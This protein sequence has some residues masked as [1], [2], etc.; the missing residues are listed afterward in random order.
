MIVKLNF[1]SAK[2]AYLQ[3]G[4]TDLKAFLRW[5]NGLIHF[6]IVIIHAN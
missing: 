6:I 5:E 3:K 1:D 4:L 2:L